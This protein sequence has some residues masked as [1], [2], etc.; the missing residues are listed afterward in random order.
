MTAGVEVIGHPLV[1]HKLTL[2]RKKS[3]S[4]VEF[5]RLLNELSALMAYEVTRD[6]PLREVAIETPVAPMTGHL[7]DGKKVV[8]VAILRAGIGI[9]DGM[10]AVVPGARVGHVGLYRDAQTL[11]AVEYYFRMPRDMPSRDV[12]VVDPMLATGNSAVAALD[13]IKATKPRSIRFVSLVS[14][15]E[16]IAHLRERHPEV[17]IYTAAIDERLNDHGYI[18]PGLG[19][20]GDRYF[21]TRA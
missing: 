9:L 19:D 1:Q 20:A 14:C 16:G 18:V 4:T 12:I 6:L 8:F 5:R 2:L 10:L 21:G 7:V 3:T 11:Q 13:R 17:P 15:P